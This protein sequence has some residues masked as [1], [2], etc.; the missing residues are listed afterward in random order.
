MTTCSTKDRRVSFS[1]L[2][3]GKFFLLLLM[4]ESCLS[5][6]SVSSYILTEVHLKRV[7]AK[8]STESRCPIFHTHSLK[9]PGCLEN[10]I[11]IAKQQKSLFVA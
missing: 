4:L 8:C 10:E 3:L 9:F 7:M 1:G 5:A 11:V 2:K 6:G